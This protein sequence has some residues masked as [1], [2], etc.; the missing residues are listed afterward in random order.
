MSMSLVHGHLNKTKVTERKVKLI[1][2]C[3]ARQL[4]KIT[5]GGKCALIMY[6]AVVFWGI[7]VTWKRS[8]TSYY[9]VASM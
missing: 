4:Q 3:K 7:K 2:D 1:V 9:R 5:P 6:V 8:C